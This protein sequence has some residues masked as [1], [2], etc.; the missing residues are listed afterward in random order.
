V[1]D[2]TR[3]AIS[4]DRALQHHRARALV[5]LWGLRKSHSKNVIVTTAMDNDARVRSGAAVKKFVP[6]AV[7]VIMLASAGTAAADDNLVTKALA[8]P[9]AGP[10]YNWSGFY[11][12]GHLGAAWGNSSWN[13]GSGIGGSTNLFQKLDTFDEGG[14]SFVG[15]QGGYNYLLPNRILLGAEVDASFPAWPTLPTGVNPFGV[16]I[17]GSSTFTSPSLGAVSLAETVLSSGTVRGRVGYAPGQWLLYATGG[18]AWTYDRQS[19][20]QVS[21]GN[22]ET[23]FLWRLGWTAGAGVEVPI[24]PHW[25]ARAEYLFFDYGHNNQP[26]FAG[27]QP[28]NSDFMLQELRVG[29]NYQSGNNATP[30]YAMPFVTKAKA[31]TDADLVNFHGQ[32]TFVWQGYPAIRSPYQGAN[33]LAGG[34]EGRETADATLYAGLRLRGCEAG[35]R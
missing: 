32:A 34:G 5:Q 11:A 20:T 24:A 27:A 31:T 18:F 8:I 3:F 23:P 33:S 6:G 12:G 14:S 22:T 28:V 29:V 30:T 10:A 13:A 7:A 35:P 16:S 1:A 21:T 25:T 17:G 4:G 26:F 15:L 19:L 2:A 9:Y